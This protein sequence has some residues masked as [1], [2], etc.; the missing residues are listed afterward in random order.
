MLAHKDGLLDLGF[1]NVS[2]LAH[3][4]DSLTVLLGNHLFVLHLFH[5]FLDALVIALFKSHDF[6]GAFLSLFNL[7][8]GLHL[9]LFEKRNT[10]GQE[11]CIPLDTKKE[12]G[13]FTK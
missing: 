6:P 9:F 3:L 2:V 11:L 7:L 8:P 12:K 4:N 5:L 13:A 10:V 1:L